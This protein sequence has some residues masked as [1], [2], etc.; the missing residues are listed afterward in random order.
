[1]FVRNKYASKINKR[2]AG[3]QDTGE[4][5]WWR[6]HPPGECHLWRTRPSGECR[7]CRTHPS[8]LNW[9]ADGTRKCDQ[10]HRRTT[11]YRYPTQEHN[12]REERSNRRD[13]Q[14]R[15]VVEPY[16]TQA[17]GR[18]TG[19]NYQEHNWAWEVSMIQII[20]ENYWS[21]FCY[22]KNWT[23]IP[24][25]FYDYVSYTESYKITSRTVILTTL[26]LLHW[27]LQHCGIDITSRTLNLTILRLVHWILQ[28]YVSYT[29]SYNIMGSILYIAIANYP[30][31][32]NMA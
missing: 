11:G 12:R 7:V 17:N 9:S 20:M 18:L 1:M 6:T 21:N 10:S 5:H 22:C 3:K 23:H 15:A 14:E 13:K 29:E 8:V 30:A 4:W 19:G 24:T 27:I 31:F 32:N 28:D 25:I 26:P 2:P 16:C